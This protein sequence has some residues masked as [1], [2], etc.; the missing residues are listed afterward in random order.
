MSLLGKENQ[1]GKRGR[2]FLFVVHWGSP[3]SREHMPA[4]ELC[5]FIEYWA[6]TAQQTPC[7][8]GFQAHLQTSTTA[9][10][11][12]SEIHGACLIRPVGYVKQVMF[13]RAEG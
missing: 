5:H 2:T 7:G 12:Y 4:R 8:S 13:N 10:S 9:R 11:Y 3:R 6:I 1:V